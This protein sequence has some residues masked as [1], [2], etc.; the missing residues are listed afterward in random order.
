MLRRP[1]SETT[2]LRT[3]ALV[4]DIGLGVGIAGAA[5]GLIL[6]LTFGNEDA[7]EASTQFAPPIG[8][9]A[10]GATLRVRY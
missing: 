3:R 5:V 2:S 6:L 8:P 9:R 1:E 10:A 7:S 4:A